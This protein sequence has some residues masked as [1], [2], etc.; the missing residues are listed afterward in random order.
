M[1]AILARKAVAFKASAV[2]PLRPID[3]P[4]MTPAHLRSD[5]DSDITCLVNVGESSA[6]SGC[7]FKVRPVRFV[8]FGARSSVVYCRH[9]QRNSPSHRSYVMHPLRCYTTASHPHTKLQ[10]NGLQ[11]GIMV[12]KTCRLAALQHLL[13]PSSFVHHDRT[14]HRHVRLRS[15]PEGFPI[16]LQTSSSG[17]KRWSAY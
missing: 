14:Q 10:L 8:P 3:I 7:N 6:V 17:R 12:L 13:R 11:I 2:I 9:D 16:L 15:H 4:P 5:S 1:I